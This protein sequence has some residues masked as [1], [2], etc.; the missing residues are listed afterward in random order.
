MVLTV[1]FIIHYSLFTA[2]V[3][4]QQIHEYTEDQPL[5]IVSDWEFPP[6]EFSNDKG[7][8]DGYNIEVLNLIL[9]RLHIP[10]RY[11][12]QEWYLATETFERREADL[13]FALSFNYMKR[14]YVMTR[15]LLH[16]YR[17]VS[18][19]R[20]DEKPLT[21]IGLLGK[22][23]TIIMKAN[24]YAPIRIL[25]TNP[26]PP[27]TIEYHSPKEA[28]TGVQRGTYDYF[29][30]GEIPIQRKLKEFGL[31]TLKTDLTDIPPGE[32]R[33]IGYDKELIDAIDDEYARLEQAGQLEKIYD[34]WFHPEREHNDTSP[35][36][37]FIII[38]A[39]IVGLISLLLS[40]LIRIRVQKAIDK[41]KDINNMMTQALSMGNYYVFEHDLQTD[42][43]QNVYGNL[44]PEESILPKEFFGRILP[45][46]RPELEDIL[47][48][49]LRGRNSAEFKAQW[50]AGTPE[51][52]DW[53]Y[54][55]GNSIVEK[56]GGKPRYIVNSVKDVTH[57]IMEER[58]TRE[59]G[60][61]YIKIFKTS[62]IAMSFYDA[63]GILH[64][65][66]DQMSKL[67][68]IDILGDTM[69]RQ[70][71]LKDMPL[72]QQDFSPESQDEFH[73]CQHLI[74]PQANIDKYIEFRVFPV[75]D[76]DCIIYYIITARDITNERILYLEQRK[77]DIEMHK[78][79]DAANTYENQ[80]QYLLEKS[81]MFVW[82]FNLKDRV[83]QL[84]RSLRK[85]EVTFS[86]QDYIEGMDPN[87]R[88]NADNNLF[89]VMMQG[90]EFNTI[91]RFNRTPI[92]PEPSWHAL[93]GIPVHDNEGNLTGYFGVAR[94]I[95][96][97]VSIQ[98]K[99]KEE[100]ARAEDSGRLKSVFLA[101]MTH[102]IRTPLNAIVGFSDLL[103]V[104]DTQE[105]RMEFIRIIRNNC[106][107]LLR[108]IND[109]LEA[110]NMG[111]ALAIK[112][113]ECDFAQ[114][115]N[116]ICQTLAQRVQEPGVEFIKDNPYDTFPATI[117]IGRIQ[118]VLTNFTTNAVKYTHQGHIK[119]G[120]HEQDGGIY[121]YCEDTGS[122]IPKEKQASVFE[123][124]VKL[125][126]FVQGTGLG[127]SI[128][129]A[130]AERCGGKIG[131]TSEGEGHGST[132]WL[133]T[134]RIITSPNKE[135]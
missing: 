6:Y 126:D 94:N 89:Q 87:E 123:R 132:F 60:E 104:V 43:M 10:H 21:E 120:Y 135:E 41:S 61:R 46:K 119:L 71:Y 47:Q 37:I 15:N 72:L 22:E 130:I 114:V 23:D 51:K 8:P 108:L 14:P 75:I 129:K 134:P 117:D 133:W 127:L 1:L 98:Q 92:S 7:E 70:T 12:M 83:I 55:H 95:T 24:D 35:I 88:E 11:V 90:K 111:Q 68:G 38:G 115:F 40:R 86:R 77:H 112:P 45:K 59:T 17:I 121:F 65:Y 29:L 28:L 110:S 25:M 109:I 19:R 79:S 33:L 3:T 84:S 49:L 63:Q 18:V 80:L 91:H 44:L 107:M 106:D 81:G 97:L 125:N 101:N 99:L 5:V 113:V 82:R 102:E 122:G 57:D 52:P 128:C 105:E 96:E 76:N 39:I 32:L 131:V 116:D 13:I 9:D 100:T 66:N 124:F 74:I 85:V 48:Q 53:R 78:I 16:F 58:K 73:V 2:T 31:D 26:E 20:P 69:F 36:P 30:W 50:N 67:C 54:L 118:Q 42:R 34:K 64:D 93:S 4:A 27:F 62:L 56:E 103:P